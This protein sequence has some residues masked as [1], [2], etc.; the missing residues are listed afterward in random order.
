MGE[1]RQIDRV[2]EY[3]ILPTIHDKCCPVGIS[4]EFIYENCEC[5]LMKEPF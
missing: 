2:G 4:G 5:V 3:V 1:E